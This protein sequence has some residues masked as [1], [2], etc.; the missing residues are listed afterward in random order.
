M[1]H[2]PAPLPHLTRPALGILA[3][4]AVVLT[5]APAAGAAEQPGNDGVIAAYVLAAPVG[6]VPSGL[7]VR[8]VLPAG[9]DCPDMTVIP[10][11]AN[12]KSRTVT[13]RERSAPQTTA[14]AFDPILVCSA[15]VPVGSSVV[16]VAGRELPARLPQRV[17]RLAM[18]GDSGCRIASWQVQ[19]CAS[20]Q[21]WPL[22]R[23]SRSVADERPDAIVINGDF[24]YREAACPATAQSLCGSSPPPIAGAPFAD[25]A[26]SWIA[27]ALLPMAP[28]LDVAPLVITRGNHEACNRGGNGYF[29]LFDPREATADTCAPVSTPSGLTA[30]PTVP[31]AT[32][33]IDLAVGPGRTLRMAIVDSAGGSDTQVTAFAAQQRP[34]Y[35]AAARLT[36][37]PGAGAAAPRRESWLLTHRPVYAYVTSTFAQPGVP[38]NPWSSMDQTAA[39]YGLLETYDLVFSSHLHLAQAV[40]LP[41][42]PGQLLLG[43]AGT[44]LDPAIGYPL[45]TSGPVV[46]PDAAYPA[47]SWAWVAPRFGYAIARPNDERGSWRIQMKDPSGAAFARCGVKDRQIFCADSSNG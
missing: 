11:A 47:P 46:G 9:T 33:A 29:L 21:A 22:A 28:M 14:P 39:S 45:P 2:A 30:A 18:L 17:D 8:A 35:E 34:A 36:A 42:L 38:F 16:S 4:L 26:Y 32:Y 37:A 20:D 23:L 24:L 25:S 43:N 13:M 44:L 41:G 40:Q 31:T 3:A 7:V 6:E 15:P 5:A 12:G 10:A 19:D 1:A 27:D